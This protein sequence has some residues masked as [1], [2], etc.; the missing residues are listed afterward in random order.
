MTPRI[1]Q[2]MAKLYEE[3][4]PLWLERTAWQLRERDTENLDWQNLAEEIEELGRAQKNAVESYLPIHLPRDQTIGH[5]W[6]LLA[7]IRGNEEIFLPRRSTI[8]DRSSVLLPTIRRTVP[9][10]QTVSTRPSVGNRRYLGH[11]KHRTGRNH[12]FRRNALFLSRPSLLP[13]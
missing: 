3:D 9:I 7:R 13:R 4:Y 10:A 6:T 5:R 8:S 12:P 11:P 1:G 2:E